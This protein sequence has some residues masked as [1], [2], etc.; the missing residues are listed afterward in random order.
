MTTRSSPVR[1]WEFLGSFLGQRRTIKIS[2]VFPGLFTSPART[3]DWESCDSQEEQEVENLDKTQ[4][5][6]QGSPTGPLTSQ[7]LSP[8]SPPSPF[9]TLSGTTPHLHTINP[10]QKA[11]AGQHNE[12][13]DLSGRSRPIF[14]LSLTVVIIPICLSWYS[15]PDLLT[16]LPLID[17]S[18]DMAYRMS[19]LFVRNKCKSRPFCS[20]YPLVSPEKLQ[21][22]LAC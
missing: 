19:F 18:K 4:T 7:S 5:C 10:R 22:I 17:T 12:H 1:P 11:S 14:P 20:H 13:P 15:D 16:H 2:V 6:S 3:S 9:P 8:S 21:F